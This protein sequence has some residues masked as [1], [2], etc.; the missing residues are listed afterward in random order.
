M[1]KEKKFREDLL[2]RINVIEL[3]IPPLR[4]RME[5]IPLLCQSLI[6]RINEKYHLQ[7]KN[8]S[9][10]TLQYLS[11]YSW[12]GNVRELG[13]AIERACIMSDSTTL[14]KQDFDFLEKK[15]HIQQIHENTFDTNT[16]ST[17]S[18]S[19]A[20]PVST[21]MP[22]ESDNLFSKKEEYE[23][24]EIQNALKKCAGNKTKAAKELGI[25]RS[26]LYDKIAKYEIN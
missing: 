24:Q 11:T 15:F 22:S 2:Y 10:S 3:E 21:V 9:K 20:S 8:V 13:H 19:A 7:I 14:T 1:V 4:D 25:S 6:H 18:A 23:K 16:I 17:A 26:L 12:P 5:D